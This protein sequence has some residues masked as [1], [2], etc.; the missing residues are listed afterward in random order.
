MTRWGI[1]DVREA[2]GECLLVLK[3]VGNRVSVV[4]TWVMLNTLT[5]G[6]ASKNPPRA[7]HWYIYASRSALQGHGCHTAQ[8]NTAGLHQVTPG[9]RGTERNGQNR[10]NRRDGRDRCLNCPSTLSGSSISKNQNQH[11]ARKMA[12]P[13][14][15]HPP[16]LHQQPKSASELKN[17]LHSSAQKENR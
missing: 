3:V 8:S 14:F 4:M 11:W 9:D 7:F 2:A 17:P 1:V 12:T 13:S 6:G 5:E 16:Y 15:Y 10:Q